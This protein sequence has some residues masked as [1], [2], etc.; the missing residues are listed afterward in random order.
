MLPNLPEQDIAV[1]A[2]SDGGLEE[3]ERLARD[4]PLVLV[5]Q[6]IH[7]LGGNAKSADIRKQ[8]EAH[9]G[10]DF[11]WKTWWDR[12]LPA[13]KDSRNFGYR[14]SRSIT[15]MTPVENVPHTPWEGLPASAKGSKTKSPSVADWR[16]WF[17]SP[18]PGMPPGRFPT[19]PATNALGKFNAKDIG[20]ALEK[21]LWGTETFLDLE[22][23]T[24]Q[25]AVGWSEALTRAFNRYREVSELEAAN[26]LPAQVG[27]ILTRLFNVAVNANDLPE[28]MRP[29]SSDFGERLAE[30]LRS[31]WEFPGQPVA[32]KQEFTAGMWR[33]WEDLKYA[34]AFFETVCSNPQVGRREQAALALQIVVSGLCE[35]ADAR[36]FSAFD[37]VLDRLPAGDRTQSLC[38]LIVGAGAGNSSSEGVLAYIGASRHVARP[39]SPS[40]RLNLLVIASLL[41]TGGQQGIAQQAS[42]EL[43]EVLVGNSKDATDNV[44]EGLLTQVR[45]YINNL[46]QAHA[47]ELERQRRSLDDQLEEQ[48]WKVENLSQ[49]VDRLRSQIVAGREESRMDILQDIVAVISGTLQEIRQPDT[50]VTEPLRYVEPKLVLALRAAGAHEFGTVGDLVPYDPVMHKAG[51]HIPLHTPVRVSARGAIMSGKFTGDRVVLK[52]IVTDAKEME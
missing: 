43:R 26:S 1:L 12:V 22:V 47:E 40:A 38:E 44:W 9:I 35:P 29:K 14:G 23:P 33:G 46:E 37:R 16:N 24:P 6:T 19:K 52:A 48:R 3:T 10:K 30:S 36:R 4:A 5:A 15:L 51:E 31:A 17:K 42:R 11:A 41:L 2:Q 45:D 18:N 25:P 28:S 8:L 50:S 7:S 27:Y 13:V 20:P 21:T 34:R 49:E 39:P 32:W